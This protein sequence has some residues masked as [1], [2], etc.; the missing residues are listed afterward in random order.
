MSTGFD[1]A[2]AQIRAQAADVRTSAASSAV[3]PSSVAD[4]SATSVDIG[5]LLKQV[6]ALQA[7][8]DQDQAQRAAEQSAGQPGVVSR[9]E[10]LLADLVGRHGA[11]GA[12]S[13]LQPAVDKAT[14][15]VEAAKTAADSGDTTDLLSLAG[16]LEKHLTRMAPAAASAGLGHAIQLVGEDLP[17]AASALRAQL[18]AAAPATAAPAQDPAA[19]T[20]A[21]GPVTHT[22][23]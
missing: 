9:A 19:A 15:L 20:P 23:N 13:P 8:V 22:F 14:A 12:R 17:E 5:A 18:A 4:A 21:S 2:A 16:A 6:Q 1:E 3:A 7:R 10:D 11:L